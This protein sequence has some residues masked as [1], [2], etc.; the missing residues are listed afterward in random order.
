MDSSSANW[1]GAWWVGFFGASVVAFF[2]AFPVT[3]FPRALPT[4]AQKAKEVALLK[5][6]KPPPEQPESA[7][8][9]G[10]D[11]APL[12][13]DGTSIRIEVKP[14]GEATKAEQRSLV[15]HIK[16]LAVNPTFVFLTLAAA[17]ETMIASGLTGFATKIFIS[18]FGITPSQ[19]SALLGA[20]SVP[21]ACGGTM[22]GGYAITKL[23]VS[24]STIVRYCCI[25]S[26][27]PWFSLFVFLYSCEARQSALVNFTFADEMHALTFP[28][29]E[30]TCNAH[31]NCSATVYDPVC[32]TDNFTYYSPCIAGCTD[33]KRLKKTTLYAPCTCVAGPSLPFLGN[34]SGF[35]YMA[36]RDPCASECGLIP[37]YG[38]AMFV[39][40][41][42]TFL[43]IVPAL[44]ALL[45]SLDEDIKS[46]GIG[47]NYV[48]IRLLGTI[49]GPV[50]FGYLI[51]KSCILWQVTCSG[52]SGSCAIYENSAM[53]KNL[54]GL[55]ITVKSASILFFF[56][57][58]LRFS[59]QARL[60]R[61]TL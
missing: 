42:F 34:E 3:S 55:M 50:I 2:V 27:V 43:L 31:C 23:E 22:L 44:T 60:D 9:K 17:A 11:M 29:L 5:S 52:K 10:D 18:M 37:L 15:N 61:F 58:S 8:Q 38:L 41:F 24:S 32:G 1:V 12:N 46:T 54:F 40:L 4:A 20:I 45:R 39:A 6:E 59:S 56:F 28:D 13:P 19:A 49:P 30:R 33:S 16:R 36:K 48:A 25:L 7:S 14:P 57:G 26:F 35:Q 47:L 51:D 21:S 53:G